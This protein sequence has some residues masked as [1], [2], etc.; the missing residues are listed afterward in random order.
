MESNKNSNVQDIRS[1]IT[2]VIVT[3]YIWIDYPTNT[4]YKVTTIFDSQGK[5]LFE[6]QTHLVEENK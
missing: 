5:K 6:N 3:E 1:F 4:K 2:N